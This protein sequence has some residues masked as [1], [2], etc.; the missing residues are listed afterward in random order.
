MNVSSGKPAQVDDRKEQS[1]FQSNH[2]ERQKDDGPEE[3]SLASPTIGK[4]S[5]ETTCRSLCAW[6]A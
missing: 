2:A 4:G 3:E 1:H 5:P 6:L